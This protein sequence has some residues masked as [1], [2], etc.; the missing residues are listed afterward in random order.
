LHD[1]VQP[2]AE[3]VKA[4]AADFDVY[5]FGYA[6]TVPVDAV[7]LSP[8]LAAAVGKFKQAGYQEVVLIGHSAG[9]LIARQFVERFPAAGVT[10]VIQVASPNTGS[11]FAALA[12]GLPKPHGSFIKS[13][14]PRPR[15]DAARGGEAPIAAGID[16]CCVVCKVPRLSGDTLVG[17]ES[18][19]PPDLQKQGIPAAL[20]AVS[21]FDAMKAPHAVERIAELAREKLVRWTPE[22]VEPGRQIVF[23]KDA[24]AAAVR[25]TVR[26][27]PGS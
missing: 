11:D 27:K 9:G 2:K 6:Q 23:S 12:V 7:S 14:A 16:F 21:H 19:W 5:A 22:Q 26:A 4:L 20:V 25:R 17:L 8:G 13:L 24:D 3:L 18:Q 1:W 15:L 10:K